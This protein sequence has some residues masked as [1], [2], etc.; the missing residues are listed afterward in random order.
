MAGDS[1]MLC[2]AV[3]SWFKQTWIQVMKGRPCGILSLISTNI[4]F[5]AIE[6]ENSS[7]ELR[8]MGTNPQQVDYYFLHL[9]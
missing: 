7:S 6:T 5:G 1:L 8:V 3:Y 2:T 4:S 9:T